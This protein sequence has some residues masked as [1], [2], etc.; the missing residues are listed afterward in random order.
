[1][2]AILAFNE[3]PRIE[4]CRPAKKATRGEICP[5]RRWLDFR[6]RSAKKFS[7]LNARNP[8]KSRDSEERSQGKE[9]K[10]KGP[11]TRKTRKIQQKKEFAKSEPAARRH[12]L[13]TVQICA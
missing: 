4:T 5:R 9:R 1:M 2:P 11:E 6:Q 10:N 7:P 12:L 3:E 8:L 13:I